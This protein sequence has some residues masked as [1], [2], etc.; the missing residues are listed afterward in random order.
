MPTESGKSSGCGTGCA[1]SNGKA[2][3]PWPFAGRLKKRLIDFW[4]N[5]KIMQLDDVRSDIER[6]RAQVNRQR[7]EICQLQRA[8]IAT[9]SA[10]AL[11]ERMLNKIDGC[12]P[13]A[14][15]SRK[16]KGR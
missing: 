14:T 8:G 5:E 11:L 9:A 15:G 1:S 13:N 3:R 16:S 6:M 2:A 7:G 10:E 4:P 12:A